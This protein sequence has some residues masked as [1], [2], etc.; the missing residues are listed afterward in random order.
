MLELFT[1]TLASKLLQSMVYIFINQQAQV[2]KKW[3]VKSQTI[4]CG[5]YLIF[6]SSR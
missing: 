4:L 2:Y 3:F 1:Y 5:I 6:A